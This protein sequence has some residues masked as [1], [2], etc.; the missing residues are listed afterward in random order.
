MMR[1]FLRRSLQAGIALAALGAVGTAAAVP[2]TLTHQGRLYDDA[3]APVTATLEVTFSIYEDPQSAAAIWTETHTV[4]F[5]EGYFSVSLGADEPFGKGVLDGKARYLGIQVGADAEMAPRSL[6]ASV[7]YA[8]MAGDVRGDITP[9]SVSIE[10]FGKVIDSDGSWVGPP[11]GLIGA[12]GPAGPAGPAGADGPT[13][14][15]GPAGTAGADG[16][17]GPTGPAGAAGVIGPTG[18][19]GIQG[20]TGAA[21]AIGP[22]GPQG[23]QGPQGPTGA[24][25]PT[26][27][28]G[29]QDALG[30][31]G[32]QPIQKPQGPTGAIG[33][34]G[35]QGTQGSTGATG[36]VGPTGPTGPQGT[37]GAVG[38]T[39]P[40]GAAGATGAVGPTGPQGATGAVG[41]TG[42]QGTTG[43]VGPTGPQGTTGAVGPTGPQGPQGDPGIPGAPGLVNYAIAQGANG[44][45][46]C[47]GGGDT[48]T[49]APFNH[50]V[51]ITTSGKPVLVMASLR[52]YKTGSCAQRGHVT[53]RVDG[54]LRVDPSNLGMA[55]TY[56]CN[57]V[58]TLNQVLQLPAGDHTIEMWEKADGAGVCTYG[59]FDFLYVAELP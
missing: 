38:P 37:T 8:I 30:P 43:A 22:T 25:G 23:I 48:W 58:A 9:S 45:S 55:S 34:T 35:P 18:P 24:V 31:T 40:Q 4:S 49:K 7:P 26:G 41:P 51:N 32:P 14:A 10:G 46:T 15:Q 47:L 28:T 16:P 21:G 19:Q 36:A 54:T 5:E 3:G 17:V 42:P 44:A 52:Q 13:G 2:G 12:T 20:P 57:A 39:G 59:T 1:S 50:T 56:E 11:T 33:P 27:P 6:I 29:A 53:L